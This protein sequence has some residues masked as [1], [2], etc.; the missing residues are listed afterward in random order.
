MKTSN[1]SFADGFLGIEAKKAKLAGNL[2]MAFNWDK[3]A[4]IIKEEF[5]KHPDLKAEAGLQGDW[6]YTGGVIFE[7]GKPINNSYTYLSSNWA[8]PTLILEWDGIEQ[9]E[10]VCEIEECK[11]FNSSTK[12]DDISLSILGLNL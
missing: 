6:D 7:N 12:W 5:K 1:L 3:A 4:Q 11:R 2:Q 8:K 10:I 9:K